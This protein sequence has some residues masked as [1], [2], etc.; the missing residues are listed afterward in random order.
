MKK[1]DLKGLKF[2]I[3][4][5]VEEHSKSRTGH[6]K[7]LCKCECGNSTSVFASHLKAGNTKSCG[8]NKPRL[9]KSPHWKGCGEIS[10]DFWKSHIVRSANGDKGRRKPIELLITIEFAWNLYLKQNKKCALS[11]LYIKFAERSVDKGWTASLDRIDSS[12][13]YTEDNV[14][15]VHKDVNMLKRTFDQNYFIKLCKLIALNN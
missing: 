8:C 5:V 2:G 13:G 4:E 11:G 14:Q 6:I 3:L 1:D 12:V 9:N 7:W 10:A 15:W